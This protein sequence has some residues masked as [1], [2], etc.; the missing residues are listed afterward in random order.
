[1]HLYTNEYA[2]YASLSLKTASFSFPVRN[3]QNGNLT[4]FF[5]EATVFLKHQ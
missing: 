2:L 4:R 1:M 5:I 3:I